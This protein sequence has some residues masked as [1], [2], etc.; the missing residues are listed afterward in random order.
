MT[1]PWECCG[2][3]PVLGRPTLADEG[4][5]LPTALC[6]LQGLPQLISSASQLL[7]TP[8]RSYPHSLNFQGA[9]LAELLPNWFLL[10]INLLFK[11]YLHLLPQSSSSAPGLGRYPWALLVF[12]SPEHQ[13]AGCS[14]G[15]LNLF[16][17]SKWSQPVLPTIQCLRRT[18][19]PWF[20]LAFPFC[21]VV[22]HI[23]PGY[24]IMF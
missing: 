9:P 17:F 11:F 13:D 20:C 24:S 4:G 22:E 18:R 16:F 5:T 21:K 1:P 8:W 19:V 12:A 6:E 2:W 23:Q 15:V 10:C 7:S 3:S 14:Q